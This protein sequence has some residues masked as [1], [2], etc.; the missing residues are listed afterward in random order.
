M[1]K[2]SLER[3]LSRIQQNAHQVH[4]DKTRDSLLFD[5]KEASTIDYD[6]VLAIG[7]EGLRELIALDQRFKTFEANLFAPSSSKHNRMLITSEETIELD[8]HIDSFLRLF[9]SYFLLT[10]AQQALEWLIRRYRVNEFNIDSLI[11]SVLP[12]HQSNTFAKLVSILRFDQEGKWGFLTETKRHKVTI[13]RDFFVKSLKRHNFFVELLCN[14]IIEYETHAT[15]S[16]TMTSF[17]TAL[18]VDLISSVRNVPEHFNRVA[19]PCLNSSLRSRNID[20]QLGAFMVLGNMAS[21]VQFSVDVLELLIRS[22]LKNCHGSLMASFTFLLVLFQRQNFERPLSDQ[23]LEM[24]V[25]TPAINDILL[26]LHRQSRSLDQFIQQTL[27]YL[28]NTYEDNSESYELLMLYITELPTSDVQKAM[29]ATSLLGRYLKAEAGLNID[30]MSAIVRAIEPSIVQ[31]LINAKLT[32]PN[33]PTQVA[34]RLAEFQSHVFAQKFLSKSKANELFLRLVSSS[35]HARREGIDQ[36]AELA[37]AQT[38]M[39]WKSFADSVSELL[40]DNDSVVV[41]KAWGLPLLQ[42]MVSQDTIIRKLAQCLDSELLPV[43]CKK[44]IVKIVCGIKATA[45]SE[46]EWSERV[47]LALLPHLLITK[48]TLTFS[49][50]IRD[51][52]ITLSTQQQQTQQQVISGAG[53]LLHGL[54]NSLKTNESVMQVIGTNITAST[55]A[56]FA[57]ISTILNTNEQAITNDKILILLASA[58]AITKLKNAS[59]KVKLSNIIVQFSINHC[60][61][62]VSRDNTTAAGAAAAASS[63]ATVTQS[64]PYESL[65]AVCSDIDKQENVLSSTQYPLGTLVASINNIINSLQ[66]ISTEQLM[67]ALTATESDKLPA[68][69]ILKTLFVAALSMSAA[70]NASLVETL[71]QKLIKQHFTDHVVL[72][73]FLSSLWCDLRQPDFIKIASLTLC[74][75]FLSSRLFV[76]LARSQELLAPFLLM[77]QNDNQEVR[78]AV[79]QC[80]VT[81]HQAIEHSTESDN[82][83]ATS[84]YFR[85]PI[86]N[87]EPVQYANLVKML[88]DYTSEFTLSATFFLSFVG[89]VVLNPDNNTFG[90]KEKEAVGSFLINCALSLESPQNCSTLMSGLSAIREPYFFDICH[91]YFTDLLGRFEASK[92]SSDEV[93]VLMVL[94]DQLV[95]APILS[96]RKKGHIQLLHRALSITNS[97]VV[98]NDKTVYTLQKT[99]LPNIV[100]KLMTM[101]TVKDQTTIVETLLDNLN[102]ADI[103]SITM[104][105]LECVLIDANSILSVLSVKSKDGSKILPELPRLNSIL[106]IIK[107]N[108]PKIKDVLLL[109]G[110]V[111]STLSLLNAQKSDS[112]EYTKQLTLLALGAISDNLSKSERDRELYEQ[113]VDLPAVL[114]CVSASEEGQTC[115]TGLMLLSKVSKIAPTKVIDNFGAIIDMI[116]ATVTRDDNHTFGVLKEFLMNTMPELLSIG[117]LTLTTIFKLFLDSFTDIP[118]HNRVELF[119]VMLQSIT[120]SKLGIL[121]TLMLEKRIEILRRETANEEKQKETLA[122]AAM[123]TKEDGV[124]QQ[125]PEEL[126]QDESNRFNDFI[127]AFCNGVPAPEMS[128]ALATLSRAVNTISVD[129][130]NVI[131]DMDEAMDEDATNGNDEDVAEIVKFLEKNSAKDNRLLQANM[132]DFIDERL[133]STSYLEDLSFKITSTD[134][135]LIEKHYLSSFSNLLVMLRSITECIERLT[136]ESSGK[137][138]KDKYLKKLLSSVNRCMDRYN[139]LLSVD[140]FVVS[141][142]K[143]LHHPDPQVRRRSLV[144][145]NEKISTLRKQLTPEQIVKFLSLLDEFAKVIE[146]PK[147]IDTNK[148]TAL[149]SFEILARNFATNHSKVFLKQMTTIIKAMG[150]GNY[151]VVSSSLICIATLC[152]ELQAKTVPYIPQFFPVLLNTLTGSFKSS[153]ESETRNLLQ[154]SCISSLEM[155]LKKIPKFLSPYLPQML[156]A[157]LHP[158]LT[159][160]NATGK[161]YTQVK[162]ILTLLTK[163][164]EFRLLLPALASA[165]EFAVVSENDQSVICLFD[166]VGDIS[167]NLGAKDVALYHKNIFKFFLQ[168]FDFRRKYNSKVRNIDLVEQHLISSFIALIM[169]LNENLFKPLFLKISDWAQSQQQQQQNKKK[170]PMNG[171]SSSS[172]TSDDAN[173]DATGDLNNLLFFYKVVNALAQHLKSIFVPYMA[174]FMENSIFLLET[175]IVKSPGHN[176]HDEHDDDIALTNSN[177]KRKRAN[178]SSTS[179]SSAAAAALTNG[180]VSGATMSTK[181][182][183]ICQVLSA[184]QKCLSFDKDNFLDKQRFEKLMPALV[185]QLENQMGSNSEAYRNRMEKYLVPCITQLA[186]TINQEM[187]WKPLNHSVLIKTRNPYAA[188]RLS[189]LS[190][191]HALHKRLGER[192][193]IL[194]PETLPFISELLEDSVPD[195]ERACQDVVKTIENHLGTDESIS[196]YL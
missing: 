48:R 165:Y 124:N 93:S 123:D 196:S 72:L 20:L 78:E 163:N 162:K 16:K 152:S 42:D 19:L 195:V 94:G 9:S 115:N 82:V 22:T 106:E 136:S 168:C 126:K 84:K 70:T 11:M 183:V 31:A 178:Q 150:A 146:S 175:L 105:T 85:R 25:G 63:A 179:A 26:D 68:L 86:T 170:K 119:S 98:D 52:L 74:Q 27:H 111:F 171:H 158:R 190:V 71:I 186:L 12:Y 130:G 46:A 28:I 137:K 36:L 59:D 57:A 113:I 80:L 47:T 155:M 153:E 37:N 143:L 182:E 194:L 107:I 118:K 29:V 166:F 187:L 1:T 131:E 129:S 148:Q 62:T 96:N 83:H 10:P 172:H 116:K 144:I 100:P 122:A 2:T 45:V 177:G 161:V 92:I 53:V 49:Q 87:L 133:S 24:L 90:R 38:K 192:L 174:Y 7:Q 132:L 138:G 65:S 17:F 5:K 145:F 120:Y 3:Q 193:I 39:D 157:L 140:G 56:A 34:D 127:T 167:T 55:D 89:S 141:V 176:A 64:I 188:V 18:L 91:K 139:Q 95:Q 104:D 23:T 41:E 60:T 81:I 51:N 44:K 108:A 147:E 35:V 33:C 97:V 110:S 185:N 13:T 159:S 184:I 69:N 32:D 191:I 125:Q 135:E 40:V 154:L 128:C 181:E 75:S 79:C 66:A 173:T 169:K 109:L 149:L 114:T 180:G 30:L 164:V 142:S 112:N 14:T 4:T 88:S 156:N 160:T 102:V 151:M 101:L 61:A 189:A 103:R 117:D 50:F 58:H 77:L 134:R 21:K 73:K 121:L 15:L 43:E 76:K 67:E 6:G 54:N 99:I 8:S